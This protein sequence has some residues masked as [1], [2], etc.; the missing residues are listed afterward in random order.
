[1]YEIEVKVKVQHS[2]IKDRMIRNGA[3]FIDAEEQNDIYFNSPMRDFSKTD[4]A[5]RIRSVNGKGEITYK[6]KKI[7]TVSKTRPEYNSPADEKEMTNILK[8]L[9]FFVSGAVHKRREIYKWNKFTIGFDSI[10]ELGEFM[11][12][13]SDLRDAAGKEEI[14][15]EIEN[16]FEFLGKYGIKKEDSIT[17]SYLEMVLEK[18]N[19]TTTKQ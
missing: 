9:G 4:E 3:V 18:N 19:K 15:K 11:E 5:L 14:Q 6:G 16:I 17:T 7:D 1:M 2:E 12:I 10:E 13:E 8:S